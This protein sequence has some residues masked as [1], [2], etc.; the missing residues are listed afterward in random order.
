MGAL[1]TSIQKLRLR[2]SRE[3]SPLLLA[4]MPSPADAAVLGLRMLRR[5]VH[6][7][8]LTDSEDGLGSLL[9]GAVALRAVASAA[10]GRAKSVGSS[11]VGD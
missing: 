1:W 4:E 8:E 6:R 11:T 5:A 2:A 9:E 7:C 3:K 10:L